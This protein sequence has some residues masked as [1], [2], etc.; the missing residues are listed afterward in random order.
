MKRLAF[1][2]SILAFPALAD[3]PATVILPMPIVTAIAQYLVRQPYADVA[4]LMAQIQGCISIQ[5]PNAQG[6]TVSHGECPAVT[7]ALAPKVEPP[8]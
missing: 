8:K 7:A 3:E 2:L 5:I 4:Q 6:V 1:I